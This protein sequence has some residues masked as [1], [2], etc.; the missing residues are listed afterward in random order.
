MTLIYNLSII[1]SSWFLLPLFYI[2]LATS[3]Y[4][5]ISF[6]RNVG[7]LCLKSNI[8]SVSV[9]SYCSV[10]NINSASEILLSR[11]IR[12]GGRTLGICSSAP[13]EKMWEIVHSSRRRI[14]VP[15]ELKLG[16]EG[17]HWVLNFLSLEVKLH[18]LRTEP[19]SVQGG[20]WVAGLL[21]I[22]SVSKPEVER[23]VES[24]I[25]PVEFWKVLKCSLNVDNCRQLRGTPVGSLY[26][27]W[28]PWVHHWD[29]EK[30]LE[31]TVPVLWLGS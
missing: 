25:H 30:H 23:T 20:L 16:Q 19:C 28:L 11:H 3:L 17:L 9:K 10:L 2:I 12:Q 22:S 29:V 24:L 14:R 13:N 15:S 21:D 27:R 1:T 5:F 7:E 18:P 8:T 26:Q 6:K 4:V 31:D